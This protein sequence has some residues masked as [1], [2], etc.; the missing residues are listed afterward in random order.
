MEWFVQ[1][2]WLKNLSQILS[3]SIV[4][5]LQTIFT[6]RYVNQSGHIIPTLKQPLILLIQ[7]IQ[8]ICL[9]ISV[10]TETVTKQVTMKLSLKYSQTSVAVL[11]RAISDIS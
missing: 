4:P 6:Y 1:L 10:E 7:Q 2:F 5:K 11:E 3:E 9:Y 8:Y